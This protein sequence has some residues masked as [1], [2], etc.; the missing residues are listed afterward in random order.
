MRNIFIA[1]VLV[2]TF[3]LQFSTAHAQNTL[4][5]YQGQLMDGGSA[6]GD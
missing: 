1:L 2:L 3:K 4:F 6:T 5:A